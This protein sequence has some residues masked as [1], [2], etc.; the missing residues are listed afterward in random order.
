MLSPEAIAIEEDQESLHLISYEITVWSHRHRSMSLPIWIPWLGRGRT[1]Y[2][3]RGVVG[4]PPSVAYACLLRHEATHARRQAGFWLKRALW[5]LRYLLSPWFRLEEE[6]VAVV[7]AAR[8]R[9]RLTGELRTDHRLGGW[10][11][12]YWTPGDPALIAEEIM[13]R[14]R[15]LEEEEQTEGE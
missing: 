13:K 7:E 14:V 9:L 15:E 2:L 10:S 5:G 3:R 6:L 11:A 8:L 12:P 1:V 4:R